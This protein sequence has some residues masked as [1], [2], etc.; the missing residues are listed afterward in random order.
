MHVAMDDILR[1]ILYG[2]AVVLSMGLVGLAFIRK[3]VTSPVLSLVDTTRQLASGDLTA[4]AG[5]KSNDE[6]GL[7]AAQT[8]E[9]AR[10]LSVVIEGIRKTSDEG[11]ITSGL[12]EVRRIIDAPA[13]GRGDRLYRREHGGA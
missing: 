11:P 3:V 2:F 12:K 4:G 6:L 10:N 13:P 9:L 5:V 8:N 7:L 1:S